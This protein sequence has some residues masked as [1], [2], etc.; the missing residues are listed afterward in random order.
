MQCTYSSAI[1]FEYFSL[2]TSLLF[3]LISPYVFIWLLLLR[4]SDLLLLVLLYTSSTP[5]LALS[6]CLP[7]FFLITTSSLASF[8]LILSLF[9]YDLSFS[10]P[11][12]STMSNIRSLA[13]L[14][15]ASSSSRSRRA[16]E[17]GPTTE[18]FT[19]GQRSAL[20][21]ENPTGANS[22]A[23]AVPPGGDLASHA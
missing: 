18:S 9:L 4:C 12:Y 16:E 2:Q 7:L 1:F 20:A 23:T 3:Q 10:H 22:A 11:T 21:V 15:A 14:A 19:G 8:Y 6:L 17:E 5:L 13:D